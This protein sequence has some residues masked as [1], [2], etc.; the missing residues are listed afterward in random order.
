MLGEIFKLSWGF[1][2]RAVVHVAHV[3]GM[4]KA[5]LGGYQSR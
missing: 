3:G 5:V 1:G 2:R 4:A